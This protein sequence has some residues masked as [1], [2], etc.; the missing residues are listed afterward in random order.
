MGRQ[1][2]H[3]PTRFW[4]KVQRTHDG[5]WTWTGFIHDGYGRFWDGYR[6]V[7]ATNREN[8]IRGDSPRLTRERHA[9]QRQGN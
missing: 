8:V 4:A 2:Q 6:I 5:C 3:A 1:R 7:R 9:A